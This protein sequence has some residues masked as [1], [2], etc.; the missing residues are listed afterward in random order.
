MNK[1][2]KMK[3]KMKRAKYINKL[4]LKKIWINLNNKLN[5]HQR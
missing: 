4:K 3:Y 5:Q 2:Y 1:F